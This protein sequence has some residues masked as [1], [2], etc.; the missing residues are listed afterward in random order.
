[1]QVGNEIAENF[2]GLRSRKIR[3]MIVKMSDDGSKAE[4]QKAGERDATFADF[5][6][7]MPTDA[8]RWAVYDLE[9]KTEDGRQ[10]S[11]VV[12]V[13][14][15]PDACTQGP[16]RFQYANGKD[17]IKA[18]LNPVHRELQINDHADLNEAEWISDFQ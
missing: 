15:S 8:P 14:Y 13:M 6:E 11:K 9:F 2:S 16:L 7:A 4:I 17:A 1:M 10:E 5:K 3:Y 18:K 12:F